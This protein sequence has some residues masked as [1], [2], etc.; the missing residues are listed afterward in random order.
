MGL[1]N[2]AVMLKACPFCG[3]EAK[4]TH[5]SL[6]DKKEGSSVYIKCKKCGCRTEMLQPI[7]WEPYEHRRTQVVAKWN[8]RVGE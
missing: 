5:R 6:G 3:G 4:V 7:V 1:E 2:E 8:R